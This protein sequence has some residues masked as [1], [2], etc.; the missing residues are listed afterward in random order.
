MAVTYDKAYKLLAQQERISNS[1]AKELIDRG[2]VKVGDKKV[3][4]ARGEIRSDTHFT[5]KEIERIKVIFEDK[6]ICYE[7]KLYK[8]FTKLYTKM[9]TQTFEIKNID[10]VNY[11]FKLFYELDSNVFQYLSHYYLNENNDKVY[12]FLILVSYIEY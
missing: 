6:N 11:K 2:V 4:I 3:L 10:N 8:Y 12:F 5:I 1:K 9:N 7:H